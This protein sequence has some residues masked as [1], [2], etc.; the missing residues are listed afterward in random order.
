MSLTATLPPY[1]GS[2]G[3]FYDHVEASPQRPSEDFDAGQ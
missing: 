2:M 1:A 3:W